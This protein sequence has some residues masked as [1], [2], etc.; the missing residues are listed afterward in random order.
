[1]FACCHQVG[2]AAEVQAV[3]ALFD[4]MD[5]NLAIPDDLKVVNRY[6]GELRS[7]LNPAGPQSGN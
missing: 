7:G 5:W 6:S 4:L 1:M 3:T 2:S